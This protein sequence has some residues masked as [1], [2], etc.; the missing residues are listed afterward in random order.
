MIYFSWFC[1]F[2]QLLKLDSPVQF[3]SNGN[4]GIHPICLSTG[5]HYENMQ[6]WVAGWGRT[7]AQNAYQPGIYRKVELRIWNLQQCA[8]TY[9]SHAPGGI[10]QNMMCAGATSKDSCLGDSG[11]EFEKM[12]YIKSN[13]SKN[14]NVIH[15]NNRSFNETCRR[16]MGAGTKPYIQFRPFN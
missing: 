7:S 2:I 16:K 13:K 14:N 11:G 1:E 10:T 12:V 8:A 5:G 3:G 4:N 15:F 9:G 6:A